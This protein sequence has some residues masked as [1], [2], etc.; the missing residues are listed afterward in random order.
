MCDPTTP[1]DVLKRLRF[2]VESFA[3]QHETGSDKHVLALMAGKGIRADIE[4]CIAWLEQYGEGG[5]PKEG[6]R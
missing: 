5:S 6:P 2:R 4:W 3:S 1:I